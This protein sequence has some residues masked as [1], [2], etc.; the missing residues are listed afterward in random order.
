MQMKST[1]FR[2]LK[3]QNVM[4]SLSQNIAFLTPVVTSS[5]QNWL[6]KV[7]KLVSHVLMV[8][9]TL[10]EVFVYETIFLKS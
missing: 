7:P 6:E 2:T 9:R 8:I 1:C 10:N 4:R 3:L 5:T